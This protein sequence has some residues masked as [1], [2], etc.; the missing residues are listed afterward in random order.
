MT[1]GDLILTFNPTV[2]YADDSILSLS[3]SEWYL[4]ESNGTEPYPCDDV[5]GIK[6]FGGF[7]T[8]Y[9]TY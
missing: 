4:T 8:A 5:L 7:V 1:I 2:Y 9:I 6:T 3:Y